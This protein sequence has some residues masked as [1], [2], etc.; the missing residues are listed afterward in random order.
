M[1]IEPG[2]DDLLTVDRNRDAD[3]VAAIEAA[4]LGGACLSGGVPV[5]LRGGQVVFE[6]E[7]IHPAEDTRPAAASASDD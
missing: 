5:T 6:R 2:V 7:R 3:R 1:R 4:D